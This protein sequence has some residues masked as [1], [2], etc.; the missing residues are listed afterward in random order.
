[1]SDETV[2]FAHINLNDVDDSRQPVEQNVYTL[3]VAKLEPITRIIKKETS[4][5]VGQPMSILK[6][7]FV[8][9]ED[10]KN[11]GRHLFQDLLVDYKGGQI[12]AKKLM[13]ATGTTQEGDDVVGWAKQFA[14][15]NPPA[16][17]QTLVEKKVKPEDPEQV[18]YNEINFFQ[19]KPV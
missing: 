10:E 7:T 13:K 2:G 15:L 3:E 5:R 14:T 9:V 1:M 16:R 8:I 19:A 17:F 6:G 4:P 18:P 12:S 11:S